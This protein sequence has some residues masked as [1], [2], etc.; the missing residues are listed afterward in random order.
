LHQLGLD[1]SAIATMERMT[2]CNDRAINTKSG[3][4]GACGVDPLHVAFERFIYEAAV[5]TTFLIAPRDDGAVR[6]YRGK[7]AVRGEDMHHI[8]KLI[9]HASGAS[10]RRTGAPSSNSSIIPSGCKGGFA[11][12]D[13]PHATRKLLR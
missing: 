10:S 4:C 9:F 6:C 3:K 2:P 5:T 11:A 12:T 13:A 7:S 8:L 1:G